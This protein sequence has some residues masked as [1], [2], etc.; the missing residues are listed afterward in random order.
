M[1]RKS[2]GGA[3]EKAKVKDKMST[4]VASGTSL[5]IQRESLILFDEIDVIFKEDHGFWSAILHFIKRSK[6][7]IVM[8][9]TDEYLQV[10]EL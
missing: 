8:T 7:P 9:T 10:S 4:E 1:T 3:K 5:N 6:K 2:A